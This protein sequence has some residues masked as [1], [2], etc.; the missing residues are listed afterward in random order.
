MTILFCGGE[1]DDFV[2]TDA[3]THSTNSTYFR[4][5]YARAAMTCSNSGTVG[6]AASFTASS[7][8]SVTFQGLHDAPVGYGT[9]PFLSL[10]TGGSAR[11]RLR[12]ASS[13]GSTSNRPVI[14]ESV[15]SGG[16]ATTLATSVTT[17][18]DDIRRRWDVIVDYQVS[19]RVRVYIDGVSL[20]DYSGDV[21]ASSATTLDSLFLA[22]QST[23]SS[24]NVNQY[25]EV[26]VSTQDS[27]TLS[28][29]TMVPNAAGTTSAWTGAYTDVDELTA[30]D[31]D[32]LTS[33]TALQVTSVNTTGMP[34]GW[35]N[36]TVTAVKVVASAARGSTGPSK[37]ALGVRTNA[38]DSF[39]TATTLDTGFSAAVATYY[40]LNPVTGVG[41]TT[42]EID[43]LQIALRSE[44]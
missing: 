39:P 8:F 34:S 32:V 3:P 5:A 36:L 2:L 9:N 26:I 15:T 27:R 40:E 18:P 42:T 25:S 11:L 12:Y 14:L 41:W 13:G 7:A 29:V 6:L 20:I 37:L 44:T 4:T 19:G 1:L 17:L 23:S 31:V 30:A 28:L 16:V 43:A 33:A 22:C 38:S 35:S 21:T 24:N 10:R